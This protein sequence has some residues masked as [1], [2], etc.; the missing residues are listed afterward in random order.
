MA[1]AVETMMYN[2]KNGK[3]WH[4]LGE[5]AEGLATSAEALQL[6]GLDWK[7]NKEPLFANVG[8]EKIIAPDTYGVVRETDK[9]VLGVVGDRYEP[10]QNHEA[11][12][13]F[14][15]LVGKEQA[16]YETAGSLMGGSRVWL[17]AK[18]PDFIRIKGHD[19]FI[20]KYV[21][22]FNSHDGTKPVTMKITPV[23]VVCNNTL[24]MSLK[25]KGDELKIRHTA[26]MQDRMSQAHEALGF[27]N[28]IYE[29]LDEI[30]NG[31]AKKKVTK[32]PMQKYMEN[33]IGTSTRATNMIDEIYQTMEEGADKDMHS[34][35]RGTL[36][37]AY[38]GITEWVDHVKD[39]KE[40]TDRLDAIWF[41]SGETTKDKA[42]KEAVKM[43]N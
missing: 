41:G 8:G 25:G 18:L 33:V 28:T 31:M 38:N 12:G 19:D 27:A 29:E 20:Q 5:S 24:T 7:V 15:E 39:Y 36:Y 2:S 1:H 4:K 3:P 23:R 34:D 43:L 22:L 35:L 40:G 26:T 16:I 30:L 42:F 11:F 10:L 13:F 21:L 17:L 6:S 9:K 37:H 14:D 32:K